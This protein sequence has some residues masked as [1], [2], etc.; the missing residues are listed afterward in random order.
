MNGPK[1]RRPRR[2]R[3]WFS[4]QRGP[5]KDPLQSLSR[6]SSTER[7]L[8]PRHRKPSATKSLLPQG[9]NGLLNSRQRGKTP[10]AHH[11]HPTKRKSMPAKGQVMTQGVIASKKQGRVLEP[12]LL[13]HKAGY[14]LRK[15]WTLAEGTKW[16]WFSLLMVV[17]FYKDTWILKAE[18]LLLG[19][20][21][22]GSCEP[23]FCQSINQSVTL[24]YMRFCLNTFYLIHVVDSLILNSWPA[25]L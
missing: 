16:S 11:S 1:K 18:P 14:F 6:E 24:F 21:H 2:R 7:S 17:T 12:S 9:S 5:G 10:Q 23:L 20:M 8:C 15:K 25:G 19:E 22:R 3:A 13:H 4:Q